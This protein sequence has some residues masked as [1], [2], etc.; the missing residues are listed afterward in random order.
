M[1]RFFVLIFV[2]FC[3]V[4]A[5]NLDI[6]NDGYPNELELFGNDRKNFAEWF[7]SIAESQFYSISDDWAKEDHDCG[8]LL[9]YAFVNALAKHDDKWL[10]KFKFIHRPDAID[11]QAYNYPAPVV[12]RSLFRTA[13]GP[14]QPEDVDTGR[15]VGRTGV[16]YL[17]NFS[18]VF[19]AKDIR[20]AK[21][22]DLVFFIRPSLASYHSM[23]YLGNGWV[24]YHTGD[25]PEDGG[26]MRLI[27]FK[28]LFEHPDAAFHPSLSNPNFLGFYRWKILS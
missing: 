7:A 24:V 17:A 20:Q 13:P 6:D 8:G 18:T 10:A 5:T 15:L 14:Y 27:P 22:G 23:V 28:K 4:Y 12:S 19:I 16:K 3:C 26:G 21:R 11:V 2:Q 9:R 25:A 1:L